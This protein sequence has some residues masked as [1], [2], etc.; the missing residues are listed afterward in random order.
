MLIFAGALLLYAALLAITKDYK[1]LPRRAQVSVKPK[2]PK[3]Y[4]VMIAKAVAISAL[5]PIAAAVVSIWS[6]LAAGIVFVVVL[7]LCLYWSTKIVRN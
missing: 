2:N 6:E 7:V 5:S 4:T 1:M 3:Q